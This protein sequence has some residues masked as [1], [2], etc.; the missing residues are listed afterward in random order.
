MHAG[1]DK[2][3]NVRD[4]RGKIC[5]DIIRHFGKFVILIP[6]HVRSRAHPDKTR[7]VLAGQPPYL[8]HVDAAVAGNV[9]RNA[10]EKY[11]GCRNFPPVRQVPAVGKI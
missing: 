11:A 1:D 3:G 7:F 9:I 8:I 6:V 5:A 2:T 4:V 10:F